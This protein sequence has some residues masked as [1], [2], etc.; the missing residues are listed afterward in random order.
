MFSEVSS[1][2]S[3]DSRLVSGFGEGRPA[4]LPATAEAWRA[5]RRFCPHV[6]FDFYAGDA[7]D[8]TERL[9][10]GSL[11]FA[12][13]L[14]PVNTVKYEFL[15]LRDS[16]RWGLLMPADCALAQK[17][18]VSREEF[19]RAPL[20]F[21]RRESLQLEIA[22]WARTEP[23]RLHVVATYNVVNGTP[24]PFVRSGLGYFLTTED[25][26]G[27]ILDPDVCFRPLEH[28]L[29]LRHALC[30]KRYPVFSKA[31]EVFLENVERAVGETS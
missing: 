23:K 4:G 29:T 22:R 9:D 16:A 15:S 11:D 30:W 7:T 31:A 5:T 6:Q 28:E 26:L 3:P 20:V 24:V 2:N 18:A 19:C 27:S 21:H 14:E 8:V 13:L 12:V 25:H 10:H 17:N 1:K